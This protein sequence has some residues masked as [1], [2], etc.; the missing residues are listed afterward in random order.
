MTFVLYALYGAVLVFGCIVLLLLLKKR[1]IFIQI[2]Q[3]IVPSE[4]AAASV[5]KPVTAEYEMLLEHSSTLL[6]R[7]SQLE[8][9]L[10][11]KGAVAAGCM[12]LFS[13]V[14]LLLEYEQQMLAIGAAVILVLVIFLPGLLRNLLVENK[15]KALLSDLPR[16][17]DLA[18]V[19]V[20]SGMTIESA[21][22]YTTDNFSK[23]NQSLTTVMRRVLRRA[24]LN[25]LHNALQELR[26]SIPALEVKMFCTSLQQSAFF[27]TSVYEQLMEL[28]KDMRDVQLMNTEERISKLSAKLAAP[29]MLLIALPALL[30]LVA[31]SIVR[32]MEYVDF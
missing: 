5:A 27:G 1:R 29:I 26:Y 15:T 8:K 22:G 17:I 2:R 12:G 21:L 31:P 24:E 3:M 30:L 4:V 20:Q 9:S 25:S 6:R 32:V 7:L 28:S 19:C 23:I 14:A 16:Y 13:V 11:L 10:P 18:A